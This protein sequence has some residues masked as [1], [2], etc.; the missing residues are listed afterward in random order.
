MAEKGGCCGISV[1]KRR[2]GSALRP[3]L[4]RNWPSV[5]SDYDVPAVRRRLVKRNVRLV[6]AQIVGQ[7][8]GAPIEASLESWRF[9]QRTMYPNLESGRHADTS[10]SVRTAIL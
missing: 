8:G 1:G 7:F 6:N 4:R 2:V 9:S 10:S 3:T 5:A